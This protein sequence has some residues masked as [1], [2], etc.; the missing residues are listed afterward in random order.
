MY[1]KK[2]EVWNT[3]SVSLTKQEVSAITRSSLCEGFKLQQ[4]SISCEVFLPLTHHISVIARSYDSYEKYSLFIIPRE[5]PFNNS[6]KRVPCRLEL[7]VSLTL[8]WADTP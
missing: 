5:K 1:K 8:G 4:E 7:R 2:S 6:G 3:A